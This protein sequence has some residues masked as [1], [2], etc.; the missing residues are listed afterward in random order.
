MKSKKKKQLIADD[1][2]LS[3]LD[4]PIYY[5]HLPAVW[6]VFSNY[7]RTIIEFLKPIEVK[8]L[9]IMNIYLRSL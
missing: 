8:I 6:L 9:L 3:Q 1:V 4:F 7:P 5:N 2:N